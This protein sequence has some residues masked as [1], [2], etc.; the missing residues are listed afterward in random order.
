MLL[1]LPKILEPFQEKV[2][3]TQQS[4]IRIHPKTTPPVHLWQSKI[5]GKPYW[6]KDS[7]YPQNSLGKPLFFLAQFN[8]AEIPAL[9]GFPQKGILQF[10]ILND[11]TYGLN[12]DAPSDNE[13]YRVVYHPEPLLSAENLENDFAFLPDFHEDTPIPPEATFA[14]DFSLEAEWLG[15]PDYQFEA[16]YPEAFLDQF[17][18]EKDELMDFFYELGSKSSGHKLGG[19]AFFTQYDPRNAAKP[20]QLLFQLDSDS[21]I[22]SMWG[23][24]GIANFFIYPEDLKN[25]RFDRVLYNWDCS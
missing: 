22:E 23:D 11:D 8:F 2:Q 7:A 18:D 12:F 24:M 4:T 20:M 5:G 6:P 10:F 3:A 16:V 25:L 13:N 21:D 19:Y 17:G 14:L 1:Q 15:P 9:E